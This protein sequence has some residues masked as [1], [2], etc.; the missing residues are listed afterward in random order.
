MAVALAPNDVIQ[1]RCFCVFG[2]Q[3][4]VNTFYYIVGSVGPSPAT[5]ADAATQVDATFAPVIKVYMPNTAGYN[6]TVCRVI[7]NS[8]PTSP[9]FSNLNA[10]VGT[11]GGTG[12]SKQT[13]GIISWQTAFAG[14]KWRGRTYLPFP[15]TDE[16]TNSGAPNALHTFRANAIAAAM[17]NLILISQAGR[18]ANIAMVLF[19]RGPPPTTTVMNGWYIPVKFATMK[20]RGNY[21]R[22]NSPP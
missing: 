11:G 9:Q 22:A 16:I 12:L 10:G 19:H 7:S 1:A 15:S 6:E 20:K 14:K 3:A 18:T 2:D 5:D 8:P 17:K 4:S 13:A 21:G